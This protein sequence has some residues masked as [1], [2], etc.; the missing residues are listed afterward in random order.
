MKRRE[1]IGSLIGTAVA[2]PI[3]ASA[4]QAAKVYRLAIVHTAI[5]VKEMNETSSFAYFKAL[6]GEL[7]RLGYVEGQNLV[8]ERYSGEGRTAHYAELAR[9]VV[10][11]R[12]DVDVI[13]TGT[14]RMVGYF[15]A[16]T[17]TI[18]IV[19]LMAD[20][21][22]YGLVSSLARPGGNITRVSS[23]AGLEIWGKRLALLR[24]LIPTAFRVGFLAS[25]TNAESFQGV[26]MREA[27]Q[28]AGVS[29]VGQPLEGTIQEAEYRRVF[30]L[31][32]R[33]RADALIVADQ[34]ENNVYSRLIIKLAEESRLP[35]LFSLR[36]F[37]EQGGLIAYGIDIV[38]YYRRGADY[39]ARILQG[40]KASELPIDQAT[41][42]ELVIN[43]KTA[44]T[45]GLTVPQI[46]LA[47]ADE[48]IE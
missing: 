36:F 23:D 12:P 46:L 6:F 26:A 42:I 9:E 24:E 10:R 28:Q 5:P 29:L 16:A 11:Q 30:E 34:A 41:K 20:P 4:Q 7:R 19:G 37:A 1:F 33:E 44:K 2:W 45:L 8:I 48:V 27:A 38:D 17:A 25:R 14:S 13:L 40:A 18:P 32:T 22:E 15:K 47:G 3:A 39:I 43:L 35:A 31:M 21:V